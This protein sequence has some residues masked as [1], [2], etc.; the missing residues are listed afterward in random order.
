VGFFIKTKRDSQFGRCCD[1]APAIEKAGQ[2]SYSY[3]GG[4]KAASAKMIDEYGG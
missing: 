3:A 1:I 4:L 2:K